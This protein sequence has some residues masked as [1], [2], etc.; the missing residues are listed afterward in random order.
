MFTN[1]LKVFSSNNLALLQFLPL[2]YLFLKL[3]VIEE[4]TKFKVILFISKIDFD[5]YK[6]LSYDV[7]DV[8]NTV[9]LPN[10][11]AY[12]GNNNDVCYHSSQ[13]EIFEYIMKNNTYIIN[14]IEFK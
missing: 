9:I 12:C 14:E 4:T 5:P 3:W 6:L 2:P 7:F 1:S 13:N 11:V 10:T 8:D